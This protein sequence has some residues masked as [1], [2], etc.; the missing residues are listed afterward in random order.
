MSKGAFDTEIKDKNLHGGE[1][2]GFVENFKKIRL[3]KNFSQETIAERLQVTPQTV[4]GWEGGTATPELGRIPAIA[5][6]FGVTTDELLGCSADEEE[7]E[8][9]AIL[10]K[11]DEYDS[12]NQRDEMR[13]C[14]DAALAKYP[15]NDRIM[16]EY[17]YTYQFV[18]PDKAIKVGLELLDHCTDDKIR[19]DVRTN[20]IYAYKNKG[21]IAKAME[22][23]EPL[24]GYFNSR[25]DVLTDCLSGKEKLKHVQESCIDLAYEFWYAIRQIKTFYSTDDRIELF[26]KSNAIYDAIYE[27]DKMPIALLRKMRNFQSM[28]EISLLS[29]RE[30]DGFYYMEIAAECAKIHDKLPQVCEVNLLLYNQGPYD[31]ANEPEPNMELRKVLLK[32]FESQNDIYGKYRSKDRYKAIITSLNS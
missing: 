25:Q 22:M 21:D 9:D 1:F 29:G 18:S 12:R 13:K 16:A 26:N 31:K 24:P 32:D 19:G 27:K 11:M 28:A 14:I 15:G 23:A 7:K 5:N 3:S 6:L 10:D 2:M 20:V 8:V 17:V 4:N 30:E